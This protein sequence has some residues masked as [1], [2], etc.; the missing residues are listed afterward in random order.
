MS[1]IFTGSTPITLFWITKTFL[2]IVNGLIYFTD[3]MT[4][5]RGPLTTEQENN[6]NTIK[7]SHITKGKVYI[8]ILHNYIT[9]IQVT[10]NYTLSYSVIT[11]SVVV[12]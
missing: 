7:V 1:E 8:N 11:R 4:R 10:Q 3:Q 6:C 9:Y 2:L 12:V 5:K